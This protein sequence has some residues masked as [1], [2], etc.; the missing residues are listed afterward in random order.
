MPPTLIPVPRAAKKAAPKSQAAAVT[1][2]EAALLAAAGEWADV[3]ARLVYADWLADRDRRDE[4]AFWRWVVATGRRPRDMN[5]SYPGFDYSEPWT[6]YWNGFAAE[7]ATLPAPLLDGGG[8]PA[9]P[10]G[11]F[12]TAGAAYLAARDRFLELSPADRARVLAWT[13]RTDKETKP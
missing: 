5:T 6:W 8:A 11:F 4:E 3:T 13:G 2:D 7:G 9:R 10:Y 1:A 12:A